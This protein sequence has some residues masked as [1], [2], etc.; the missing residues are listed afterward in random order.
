MAVCC[1]GDRCGCLKWALKVEGCL[2]ENTDTQWAAGL[3]KAISMSRITGCYQDRPTGMA[4]NQTRGGLGLYFYK[5]Y[6]YEYSVL[7]IIGLSEYPIF[8]T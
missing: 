7:F 2:A 5:N 8:T 6:I 4:A 1:Q 3:S